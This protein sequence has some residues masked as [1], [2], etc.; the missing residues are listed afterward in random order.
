MAFTFWAHTLPEMM[1][2]NRAFPLGSKVPLNDRLRRISSV[3]RHGKSWRYQLNN[4]ARV[5]LELILQ[6][7]A[8]NALYKLQQEVMM[9]RNGRRV[10][11]HRKWSFKYGIT[12]YRVADPRRNVA[13]G[14]IAED[15]MVEFTRSFQ[16]YQVLD[17]PPGGEPLPDPDLLS[18]M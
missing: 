1:S 6:S 3:E 17:T 15:Q 18:V 11:V 7:I 14:W 13:S 10:V 9:G 16:L 12:F 5:T 4:G 8:A 2:H